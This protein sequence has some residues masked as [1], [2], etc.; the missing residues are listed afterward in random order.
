MTE[1][2]DKQVRQA[3][4]VLKSFGAKEVYLFG[5]AA[6][7]RLR[8]HSDI[9]LAVV[10]LPPER[11]F[12]AMAEASERLERALDLV[13]L[14]KASPFVDHLRRWDELKRVG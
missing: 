3:A 6:A 14:D 4:E 9:D 1:D 2:L 7:G 8:R 12:E 5:S 13:D 10:G 11:F